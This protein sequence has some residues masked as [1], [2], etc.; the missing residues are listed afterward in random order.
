MVSV[1]C[2]GGLN[3][4]HVCLRQV[5]CFGHELL[6]QGNLGC[7]SLHGS[8]QPLHMVAAANQ[9]GFNDGLLFHYLELDLLG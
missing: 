9:L 6:R 1:G 3:S 8:W 4:L 5:H 7:L 2:S